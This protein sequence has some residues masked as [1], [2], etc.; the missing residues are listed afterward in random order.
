MCQQSHLNV[1]RIQLGMKNSRIKYLVWAEEK[2]GFWD[3]IKTMFIFCWKYQDVYSEKTVISC[4]EKCLRSHTLVSWQM[5]EQMRT[6]QNYTNLITYTEAAKC[7][8]FKCLQKWSCKHL[9][10]SIGIR[11][12][13][14]LFYIYKFT[15]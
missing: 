12:I 2:S 5:Q 9:S 3:L 15:Y 14:Y 4:R 11:S 13:W 6:Y 1:F 7:Q 10:H 8:E